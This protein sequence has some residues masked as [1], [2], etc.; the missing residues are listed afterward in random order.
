[1][2][3][4]VPLPM[5]AASGVE[6]R[7]VGDR[8]DGGEDYQ[9]CGRVLDSEMVIQH[10]SAHIVKL[11]VTCVQ[12]TTSSSLDA[13]T[14]MPLAA[15]SAHRVSSTSP[16]AAAPQRSEVN[17]LAGSASA[18]R[19]SRRP[20]ALRTHVLQVNVETAGYAA[21]RRWS[22]TSPGVDDAFA[23]CHGGHARPAQRRPPVRSGLRYEA[24]ACNG[25]GYRVRTQ[26]LGG[27]R[28]QTLVYRPNTLAY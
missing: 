23:A 2:A 9:A 27:V 26:I 19:S 6:K 7:L 25:G 17:L 13:P 22:W 18:K 21:H 28:L 24:V 3:S 4:D 11:C 12:T 10:A 1:M 20:S 16:H 15:A 8:H 5:T 14:A